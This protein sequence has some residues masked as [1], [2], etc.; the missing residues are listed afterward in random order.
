MMVNR[1]RTIVKMVAIAIMG[2]SLVSCSNQQEKNISISSNEIEKL[3]DFRE[4]AE[5]IEKLTIEEIAI[6]I[7]EHSNVTSFCVCE[8]K[9]Y[10]AVEF[11]D[12]LIGP[13]QTGGEEIAFEDKYNTQIRAFCI[14]SKENELL[15]QYNVAKC[16]SVSDIQCNGDSLSWEGSSYDA[17][18]KEQV[19]EKKEL[20]LQASHKH[21]NVRNE[22]CVKGADA[23]SIIQICENTNIVNVKT[24]IG[25]VDIKKMYYQYY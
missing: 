8:D 19:V 22:V 24:D 15:Y 5:Q 11:G 14:E 10:Y 3:S 4:S 17:N 6:P 7:P 20:A 18:K 25:A 13:K 21:E 12:Y 1:N 23:G 16:I 2:V 9:V